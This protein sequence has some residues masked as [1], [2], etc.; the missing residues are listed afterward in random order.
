MFDLRG[1][2]PEWPARDSPAARISPA[3]RMHLPDRASRQDLP[4]RARADFA[5][6]SRGHRP[7]SCGH[8]PTSCG[9]R[10][11]IVRTSCGHRAGIVRHRP[12]IA[13]PPRRRRADIARTSRG[14]RA[15]V[16][17]AWA[18]ISCDFR[19][20]TLE[21]GPRG[22]GFPAENF[23]ES[24]ADRDMADEYGSLRRGTLTT[25]QSRDLR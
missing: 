20:Q 12:A 14:R 8:R 13:R 18:L 22:S 19:F 6:S 24:P 23:A 5:P 2:Q 15:G 3:V 10:A 7:T 17:R 1:H 9:H 11:G 16:A 4:E 21:K 25:V